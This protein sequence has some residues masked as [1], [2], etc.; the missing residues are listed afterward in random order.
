[1]RT[2]SRADWTAANEAWSDFGWQWQ[3]VRRIAAERGFI[4]PPSGSAHDDRDAEA[5]SQRAIIW[6]ALVDNPTELAAI[7]GRASS[8]SGVIDRIIGL[9]ARLRTDADY[10]DKDAQWSRQDDPTHGEAV[11]TLA[12]IMSRIEASR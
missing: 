9:E 11:M 12:D 3:A 2:Y 5:P 1:M 6:R 10:A 8:W 7:V 4:F